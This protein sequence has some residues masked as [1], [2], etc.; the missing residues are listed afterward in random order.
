M[1]PVDQ[2]FATAF[3]KVFG[4]VER[5]IWAG[6][7]IEVRL[8]PWLT[9][10]LAGQSEHKESLPRVVL[11]RSRDL[12]RVEFAFVN[13]KL[14]EDD[15]AR[16][17]VHDK[18]R[19]DA[20]L[21]AGFGP[22]HL[23]EQSFFDPGGD[24]GAF[25]TGLAQEPPD[26]LAEVPNGPVRARLAASSRVVF[27]VEEE[28]IPF[29]EA[30]LLA[31]MRVLP[32][33][34]APHAS[35][36]PLAIETDL[37]QHVR[38]LVS[39]A[40][41]QAI[42]SKQAAV[43]TR[44][45][46][47]PGAQTMASG[48]RFSPVGT[49]T[50]PKVAATELAFVRVVQHAELTR[51]AREL[52]DRFG[53]RSA[54]SLVAPDQT[55]STIIGG[56]RR[57][58]QRETL[59]LLRK[60]PEVRQ[61]GPTETAIEL[62]TRLQ[63]SP[64][65]DAAFA[66]ALDAV[67]HQGRVE[68]WHS[69]LAAHHEQS[70]E[71][72]P[73]RTAHGTVD[74]AAPAPVDESNAVSRT[75]RAVW[76]R[77][78]PA[79]GT[80][81]PLPDKEDVADP[82]PYRTSLTA[83]DRSELVHQ[84][85]N[86]GMSGLSPQP[87]QVDHLMLSAGGGWLSSDWR[88]HPD[89]GGD[90]SLEQWTHRATMGRDQ[91]VKVVRKGV[92]LPFG[93]RASVVTVTERRVKQDGVAALYTRMF[94][95]VREPERTFLNTKVGEH[96]NGF[97][98]RWVR[99]LTHATPPLALPDQL[100]GAQSGMLFIPCVAAQDQPA[101]K[102]TVAPFHFRMLAT[103]VANRVVEFE[104]PLVFAE[105]TV[106][107]AEPKAQPPGPPPTPA[108]AV[109]AANDAAKPFDLRGQ[110]VA[111]APSARP[112]DTTLP[113][114]KL[115]FHAVEDTTSSQQDQ[116]FVLPRLYRADAVVPAMSAFTGQSSPVTLT[117]A[118]AYRDHGFG[119]KGQGSPGNQAEL[120]LELVTSEAMR[121]S[122]Q[123]DRS[124]GFLSPDLD[125]S[126]LARTLGP[127]GG[128]LD[129]LAGD[130]QHNPA[131]AMFGALDG[132][133]LFGVLPLSKLLPDI[134]SPLPRFVTQAVNTV[135]ALQQ[136]VTE[137]Q[138]LADRY[139]AQLAQTASDVGQALNELH[140]AAEKFAAAL[141]ALAQ[142]ATATGELPTRLGTLV[143][144][145]RPLLKDDRFVSAATA[146]GLPRP[147][148]EQARALLVRI[149][150]IGAADKQ[151][152]DVVDLI[153]KFYSGD[154]LPERVSARLEW[155]TKLVSWPANPGEAVFVPG[156]DKTLRLVSEVQAPLRPSK[157]TDDAQEPPTSASVGT[158]SALVSCSL[159]PFM[160]QLVGEPGFLA[161]NV[162]V[163]EFS[164]RPGDKPDVNVKLRQGNGIEFRGPLQFVEALKQVIPFDGFSDPPYLDLQPSGIKAGFDLAV[165]DLAV[166]VFALTNIH[167]GAELAVPF[168]GES[169][170]LRLHFA[171]RE[172]PFRL[173]VAM[174]AGGGFFAM[175]L[176]PRGVRVIEAAFEFGAAVSMSFVVA[177]GSV[178]VMA[179]IY[180]RLELQQ[181]SGGS[182]GTG[183]DTQVVQLTGFFRARG[184]VDVLGLVS[185]CIEL[186]LELSYLQIET[187]KGTATKA[188][189]KASISV[190]VSIC[191]ASFSVTVSCEKRFAGSRGD[192][193]F[194]DTMGS[195][196]DALGAPRDPWAE[197]C[198]A[199][200]P[201]PI[202]EPA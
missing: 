93:H 135:V 140:T 182:D 71:V 102:S 7:Q 147:V 52:A 138:Q 120:F 64:R 44:P 152:E 81:L 175:T 139:A 162:E 66:H 189:G 40:R 130:L 2:R 166:G 48:R 23:L 104:G 68:L 165:P 73:A 186:Y 199:F 13:L 167:V 47:R 32:L 112:D 43:G 133:N 129:Q 77:D 19:K 131:G 179:G 172:N 5:P 3:D 87:I 155:E 37:I 63:L 153:H 184:R 128:K 141:L 76:T 36:A 49:R 103:D 14:V 146:T 161:I 154:L 41:P 82:Q 124:G 46:A 15:G 99:I 86:F 97:P 127:V 192:P 164:V 196:T 160:I 22:Q 28:R 55:P 143:A 110:R 109:T 145:V 98:F 148:V 117:Y 158:A 84:T 69:R 34:V 70:S 72:A 75:V 170:E 92:L 187:P 17:L 90:F 59:E 57:P 150:E 39:G 132:A 173:Q 144:A 107:R 200:A 116:N 33:S 174:F 91:Y 106:F 122:P 35:Y 8:P 11:W 119:P 50:T 151:V 80:T 134:G 45:V 54:I 126:A 20:F 26:P 168:I 62:P 194:L 121:F 115:V 88:A 51:T 183:P 163:M 67:E 31:A 159:P 114:A 105:T 190:E 85:S 61:P 83:R 169:L 12:V 6:P 89:N 21:I 191:F 178:E 9:E 18:P 58:T 30:G 195:Y 113:T 27:T 188:V 100:P 42:A 149:D 56:G 177:S 125:V 198:A 197:Y 24:R 16:L 94:V 101:K 95:V 137:V 180:F 1:A 38:D 25:T 142:D 118:K 157:R 176:S 171:T 136:A 60:A 96:D 53:A 29:T 193:T 74:P 185:V 202:G 108:A 78:F 181:G 156:G 4:T 111:Y 10:E 123:A 79:D 65:A 201:E